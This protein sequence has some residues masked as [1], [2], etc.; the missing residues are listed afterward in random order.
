MNTLVKLKSSIVTSFKQY[1]WSRLKWK[2]MDRMKLYC[3]FQSLFHPIKAFH[4]VKFGGKASVM[5]ATVLFFLNFVMQIFS[6]SGVG[7]IFNMNRPED[8]NIW[9]EFL[10]SNILIVLWC[11]FNW[12]TTTLFNG[13]GSFKQIWVVTNYA[14]LPRIVFTPFVI[15]LSN[16]IS[17]DE[18]MFYVMASSLLTAW[19]LL[20]MLIGLLIIH[21]FTLMK[22]IGSSILTILLIIFFLFIA[23]LFVSIAQQFVMFVQTIIS[24]MMLR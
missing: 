13:E 22:T 19:T 6:Y 5:I 12:A 4:E 16:V 9:S 17:I 8:F 11:V 3:V 2:N 7:F 14:L 15:L 10:T 24:E 21:Q 20:S 23:L 1:D 18:M